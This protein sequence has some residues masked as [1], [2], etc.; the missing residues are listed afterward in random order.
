MHICRTERWYDVV[1]VTRGTV[2]RGGGE[3]CVRAG[4]RQGCIPG[5]VHAGVYMAGM[6]WPG[7]SGPVLACLS[8]P[9]LVF[10]A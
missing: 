10:T 6:S 3:R 5:W 2:V 7:L 8:L 9:V 4:V 1:H